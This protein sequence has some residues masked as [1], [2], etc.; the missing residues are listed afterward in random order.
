MWRS[1]A[2]QLLGLVGRIIWYSSRRER[3]QF[4]A[5]RVIRASYPVLSRL[6]LLGVNPRQQ[7]DWRSSM[8]NRILSVF[9][10]IDADFTLHLDIR[11]AWLLKEAHRQYGGVLICTGHFGLTLASHKGLLDLGLDPVFI[12]SGQRGARD[13]SGWNWGTATPIDLVDSDRSDVLL[14]AARRLRDGAVVI[15]YVDFD[16]L[17]HGLRC[18][19]A[20]LAI[21]PNAF[22]WAQINRFPM[23]F[24][25]SEP[26][27]DGRIVL[28]FTQPIHAIP[29]SPRS[30]LACAAEF[31]DFMTSRTG[32]N[33]VVMRP[34]EASRAL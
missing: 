5:W 9:T 33:H 1:I 30:A 34:K 29:D 28:E 18:N 8:L 25:A 31:G 17:A 32:R 7:K 3:A 21:S 20:S 16:P 4:T 15:G 26:S 23:L 19:P 6:Y 22:S 10:R 11:G 12:G 24:M 13:M 14:Q 27:E 2:N